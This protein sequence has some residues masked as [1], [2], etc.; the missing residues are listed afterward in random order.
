MRDI[1]EW[2]GIGIVGLPMALFKSYPLHAWAAFRRN[3]KTPGFGGDARVSV[4]VPL[5]G[6]DPG[7]RENLTSLLGQKG[8]G[9]HEVLLCVEDRADA[10]AAVAEALVRSAPGG[11]AR[12]VTSGPAGEELGKLHNLKAGVRAA[13]G[14]VLVLVDSDTRMPSSGY[15]A[16]FIAPLARPEVGCVTCYPAI[17]GGRD[18]GA[19]LLAGMIN[20]DLWGTFVVRAAWGGGSF[21][22]GACM[23]LRAETLPR[24]GGLE[25]LSR[26]MLMDSRLAANIA[27][28]GLRV[29]V[30]REPVLIERDRVSL[31]ELWVQ[32]TRWH[33]AMYR[34]LR[35]WTWFAFG[36]L[37]SAL[38]LALAFVAFA[39]DSI[40]ARGVLLGVLGIRAG[41]AA[42][43]RGTSRRVPD[44]ARRVLVQPLADLVGAAAWL[45]AMV[46]PHV[47]W[48]SRRY[49]VGRDGVLTLAPASGRITTERVEAQERGAIRGIEA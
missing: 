13:R 38:V 45:H 6:D 33:V 2:I 12:L 4:I 25:R 19:L 42:R 8:I 15:L 26:R 14:S 5:R 43:L 35:P 29:V 9:E 16:E 1:V 36:W 46:Q 24:C 30:H 7:L 32:S 40:A 17:R 28:L 3:K 10:A 23:A 18:L 37:R 44:I 41:Q 49:R 39:P 21:A 31:R 48:R 20:L 34:G 11:R 27:A 47:Q 22:N